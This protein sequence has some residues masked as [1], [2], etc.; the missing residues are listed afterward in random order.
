MLS[1]RAAEDGHVLPWSSGSGEETDA[2][3]SI[4]PMMVGLARVPWGGGHMSSTGRSGKS[5]A[6]A[7]R[8]KLERQT[9]WYREIWK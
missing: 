8:Q 3:R 6:E 7:C 4:Q 5:L 2:N 1:G 9:E